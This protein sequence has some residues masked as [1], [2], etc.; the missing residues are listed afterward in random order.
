[1]EYSRGRFF[2]RRPSADAWNQCASDLLGS[3]MTVMT[4]WYHSETSGLS[5]VTRGSES[6]QKQSGGSW[7]TTWGPLANSLG[8]PP[9]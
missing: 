5:S 6:Y 3:A 2:R 8:A 7:G 4:L 1:M 9:G